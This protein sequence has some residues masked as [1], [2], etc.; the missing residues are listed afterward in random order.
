MA[1]RTCARCGKVTTAARPLC[2]HCWEEFDASGE[3]RRVATVDSAVP[4]RF[5]ERAIVDWM[6]RLR[7]EA[8]HGR[9]E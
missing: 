7:A 1:K 8:L 2:Q 3:G 4:A 6:S 9:S 5:I